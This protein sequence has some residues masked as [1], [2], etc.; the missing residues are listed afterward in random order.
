M[1]KVLERYTDFDPNT[2]RKRFKSIRFDLSE[3]SFNEV[4]G[5]IIYG[6]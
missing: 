1:V 2:V 6:K 5:R 3:D 4:H